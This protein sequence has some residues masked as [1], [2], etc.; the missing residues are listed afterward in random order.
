M[1]RLSTNLAFNTIAPFSLIMGILCLSGNRINELFS[2]TTNTT[3]TPLL[4]NMS[5]ERMASQQVHLH[6]SHEIRD[7]DT[8]HSQHVSTNTLGSQLFRGRKSAEKNV[9]TGTNMNC[10]YRINHGFRVACR[11]VRT[12]VVDVDS[13]CDDPIMSDRSVLVGHMTQQCPGSVITDTGVDTGVVS[14]TSFTVR[15]WRSQSLAK[16]LVLPPTKHLRSDFEISLFF[17]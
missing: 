2:S 4:V 3:R 7:F 12:T 8:R 10:C 15:T 6:N 1:F 11:V 16:C 14:V 13:E 9:P 17:V 5:N